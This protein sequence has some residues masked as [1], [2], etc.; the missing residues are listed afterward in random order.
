MIPTR[1][2]PLTECQFVAFDFE[3]T[4]LS[5]GLD[6]VIEAGAVN[7]VP[8]Q[9]ERHYFSQL[10][11]P[12]RDIPEKVI[13]IHGITEAEVADSPTFKAVAPQ[14]LAFLEQGVLLAHH[15]AFDLAF[16]TCE[17]RLA[18]IEMPPLM[19]LDS[20]F[21]A[22]QLIAGAPSYGLGAL[23]AHLGLEMQGNAHRALPDAVGCAD[24]FEA[25]LPHL[26]AGLTLGGLL[27][28]CPQIRVGLPDGHDPTSPFVSQILAAMETQVNL[29]MT[30]RNGR[31]EELERE[32]RP[33]M[34]GGFGH[35]AYLE[36]FC[37]LRDANRQF[38]L[39]RILALRP[40]AP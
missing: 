21:L 7:F 11:Q 28:H 14:L 9:A 31:G 23:I 20:F 2:T 27:S 19:V 36:A 37:A 12:E 34:L 1:E 5:A 18:E 4:G 32:V 22:R 39:N 16:L 8:G 30:Y 17:L 35:F 25:C 13:A 3:T 38:R 10:I 26:P 40:V 33:L 24:L 29:I 15:A 6:R